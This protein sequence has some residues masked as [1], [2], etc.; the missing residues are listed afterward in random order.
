MWRTLGP[1]AGAGPAEGGRRLAAA[2][3]AFGHCIYYGPSLI[4]Q[5]ACLPPEQVSA[6]SGSIQILYIL[7]ILAAFETT[8][9]LCAVGRVYNYYY[10]YYYYYYD[11]YY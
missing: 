4:L 11:Y 6:Q 3:A 7:L 9:T 8:K 2:F 5:E 10:Y 1:A